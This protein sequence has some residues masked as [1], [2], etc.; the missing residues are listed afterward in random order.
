MKKNALEGKQTPIL[1]RDVEFG[2]ENG[3]RITKADGYLLMA[4]RFTLIGR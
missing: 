1:L 4:S 2:V 3:I